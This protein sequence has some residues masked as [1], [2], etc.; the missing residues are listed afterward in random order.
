MTFFACR[1][2]NFPREYNP[3]YGPIAAISGIDA[4]ENGL[5]LSRVVHEELGRG[6]AAFVKIGRASC[7]ERV[8]R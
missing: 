3:L 5:H 8:W 6:A 1:K 4:I 2:M 7:R